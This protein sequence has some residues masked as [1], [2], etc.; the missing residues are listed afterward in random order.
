M[1]DAWEPTYY[2]QFAE[3]PAINP[4][5][6][7]SAGSLRVVRG[8]GWGTAASYCR[9]SYRHAC[10][11]TYRGLYLSFRVSLVADY[12]RQMLKLTGPAM[13]GGGRGE[14]SERPSPISNTASQILNSAT[15]AATP[16]APIDFAAERKAA[17]RFLK[18]GK[19][20]AWLGNKDR[21]WIA[22]LKEPL[23]DEP[24]CILVVGFQGLQITDDEL[25]V[26]VGCRAIE[27]LDLTD[28]RKVTAAGLMQLGSL[29][30]LRELFIGGSGVG[31]EAIASLTNYPSLISLATFTGPGSIN[32]LPISSAG[33]ESLPPCPRLRELYTS[34]QVGD[35]G[36]RRIVEQCPELR[37]LSLFDWSISDLSPLGRLPRLRSLH[38][39]PNTLSDAG[40]NTLLK[41]PVLDDLYVDRPDISGLARL[42][43]LARKLTRLYLRDQHAGLPAN[44]EAWASVTQMTG[45]LELIIGAFIV[46][47]G[48]ALQR[49]SAMP[50]LRRFH[51]DHFANLPEFT[52]KYRTFTPDD[53]AAF[54]KA[55]PDVELSISGQT[56][57]ALDDWPGKFEGSTSIAP[58]PLL[59]PEA[60]APA[61]GTFAPEVARQR[62]AE[63][64][65][66]LKQPV[67][68]TL[69]VAE[70]VRLQKDAA[71][72]PKPGTLTSPATPTDGT[73]TS[74]A[75]TMKF[76]LIPPGEAVV[77]L[78]TPAQPR[79]A[80]QRVEKPYYLGTTEVT[81]GQ[82][83]QFVEATG[84]VTEAELLKNGKN[85]Q[86]QDDPTVTWKTPGYAISDDLPV[87]FVSPADAQAFCD[88][89]NGSRTRESSE[90]PTKDDANANDD[91]PTTVDRSL[92]TDDRSLTTP[93]TG[94][95][96]YRLPTEQEWEL[97][98]R[99]GGAGD[100]GFAGT[101]Q[102]VLDY[103]W[104]KENVAGMPIPIQPVA[105]KRE[106]PFGLY[107][108]LGNVW[109]WYATEQGLVRGVTGSWARESATRMTFGLRVLGASFNEPD[110]GFRVLRQVEPSEFVAPPKFGEQ[111]V[112]VARGA[113][114]GPQVAVTHPAAISGLRSWTVELAAHQ[115][116]VMSIAWSPLG[117]VIATTGGDDMSVRLWDRD[118]NLKSI[119]LGHAGGT[120]HGRYCHF[121]PDGARLATVD[122]STDPDHPSA[123]RIWN[124]ST[125]TC[126]A[127]VPYRDHGYC[128]AW[129]PDG[130]QIAFGYGSGWPRCEILNVTTGQSPAFEAGSN[131]VA[132]SADSETVCC[133]PEYGPPSLFH[134]ASGQRLAELSARDVKPDEWR[135]PSVAWSPDGRWLA[136]AHGNVVRIWDAETRKYLRTITT[137][138]GLI[139]SLAW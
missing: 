96:L 102:G 127:V 42:P 85:L 39:G 80:L 57:P 43:R 124:V 89:L 8:G 119:L 24:F 11:P 120:S 67:E 29:P 50:D 99:A 94:S 36:L 45:L 53:I 22:E 49:I 15:T 76:R 126:Q 68:F 113:A 115:S 55:R 20:T 18:L 69:D 70:V 71:T 13:A 87:N 125:G 132:W 31:D 78:G 133:L 137:E 86:W 2:G 9:S 111:P 56:Y 131:A 92:T 48:P 103:A 110:V 28:Q 35:A 44:S 4:S 97:A 107:D 46:V 135:W 129:S 123:L 121:S 33:W 93:A 134:A 104:T 52:A 54:R 61:V 74:P 75:T 47:D 88:W 17:E 5:S 14:T 128:V 66:F 40:I 41:L 79:H 65:A 60:P 83:K 30:F 130:K 38:T 98:C 116:I 105:M 10:D 84:H 12:V 34:F 7:S 106:N 101:A 117:D 27:K 139:S 118:G 122:Q 73:L 23:P 6:P 136:C 26:L 64:A 63:W 77:N 37:Q 51:T 16:A 21:Q 112:L 91:S 90:A 59:S 32:P 108:V 1:E 62:Q 100:Y 138:F 3:K 72:T 81:V 95:V 109:E 114:L 82:F 19:G 58:W 25:A